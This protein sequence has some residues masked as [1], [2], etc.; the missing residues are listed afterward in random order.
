MGWLFPYHTTTKKLLVEDVLATWKRCEGIVHATKSCKAGMWILGTPK[1]YDHKII[2]LYL[3]E[4]KS[5]LWGYKDLDESSHPYY[6]DCPVKWLDEAPVANQAWRDGVH[7]HYKKK[8]EVAAKQI[9][10]NT[11]YK[12]GG[13]WKLHGM[14]IKSIYVIST[15]PL[16]GEFNGNRVRI[17]RKMKEVMEP[18]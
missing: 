5:G 16:R 1:G 18:V 12:V 13:D 17:P 8:L 15:K 11:T 3:M 4:R 2:G 7:A 6:Y 9:L 14:H 10:A